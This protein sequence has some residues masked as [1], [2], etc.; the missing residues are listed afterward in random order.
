M[1]NEKELTPEPTLEKVKVNTKKATSEEL[2][3]VPLTAENNETITKKI[4]ASEKKVKINIP[5]TEKDKTAVFVGI[6]G[7]AYNIP[8]DK[9]VVV[10]MSVVLVLENAKV[11]EYRV[12]ENKDG[13]SAKVIAE[14]RTRHA[15]QTKAE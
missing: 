2:R 9:W 4:L 5:S 11:T 8:R 3:L 15:F 7:V 10:P 13:D 1:S 12:I 14:D 6:N